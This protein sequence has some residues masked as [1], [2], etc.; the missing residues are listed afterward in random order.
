[1]TN[2]SALLRT[3][4]ALTL[5][6]A[7]AACGS[8][9]G[10]ELTAAPAAAGAPGSASAP[11]ATA[12]SRATAQTR[13]SATRTRPDRDRSAYCG[14][15]TAVDAAAGTLTFRAYASYVWGGESPTWTRPETATFTVPVTAQ[16]TV[17][18]RTGNIA[19]PVAGDLATR[20]AVAQRAGS[21][22]GRAYMEFNDAGVADIAINSEEELTTNGCLDSHLP[23]PSRTHYCGEITAVDALRGT[24]TFDADASYVWGGETF[25]VRHDIA[26]ITAK[27]NDSTV[28][29]DR[30]NSNTQEISGPLAG[31]LAFAKKE[32][33]G[34][35]RALIEV[36]DGTATE[37]ELNRPASGKVTSGCPDKS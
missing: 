26:V 12:E 8:S 6:G 11:A 5:A 21:G 29:A 22:D 30:G 17:T 13:T 9:T 36:S 7:L 31:R 14:A 10:G 35:Q 32:G 23:D 37:I 34:T 2:T 27:V 19:R 28:V 16:T 15:L 25:D 24:I 18:D 4:G 33:S 20:L 3:A 1:M